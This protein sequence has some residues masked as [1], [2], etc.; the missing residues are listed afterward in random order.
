LC[1]GVYLGHP[2]PGGFKYGDMALQIGRVSNETVKYGP[3][4]ERPRP[5]SDC[6]G[7]AEKQVY[8]ILQARSLVREGARILGSGTGFTQPREYKLR[9]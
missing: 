2:V 9:S 5:E 7:N 3:S 1:L 8:S 4:S 6:S